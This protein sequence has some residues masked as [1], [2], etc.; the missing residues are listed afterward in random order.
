ML[1]EISLRHVTDVHTCDTQHQ[2]ITYLLQILQEFKLKKNAK[3][4]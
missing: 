1:H 4:R 3:V 2:G